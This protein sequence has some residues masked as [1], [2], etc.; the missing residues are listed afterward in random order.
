M[1]EAARV[2]VATWPLRED[3]GGEILAPGFERIYRR[4]RGALQA[5]RA[6]TTTERLHELRKR[7]KDTWHAAQLARPAA[8][9]R[10][11]NLARRA[12]ALSDVVGEDHDLAVLLEAASEREGT[13]RPGELAL[14]QALAER[15]RA[16]LQRDA[17]G[18]G[19]R[20]FGR[21]PRSHAKRLAHVQPA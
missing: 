2:R 14:L 21:K 16:A 19:R 4:G 9:K 15:R 5:A 11:K 10:M 13:L 20:V 7:T 8:P 3:A 1:L 18:R 17:L 6:D 12:H